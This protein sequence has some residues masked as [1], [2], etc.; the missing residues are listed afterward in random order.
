[1]SIV[2][3]LV[4][5]ADETFIITEICACF[6]SVLILVGYEMNKYTTTEGGGEVNLSIVIFDLPSISLGS[7]TLYSLSAL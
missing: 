6:S 4:D 5:E 3:D 1:M 2:D 7:T